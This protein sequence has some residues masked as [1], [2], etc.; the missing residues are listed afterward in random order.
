[1]KNKQV[2]DKHR[3][4]ALLDAFVQGCV[5]RG[6]YEFGTVMEGG[7]VAVR[8]KAS[9]GFGVDHWQRV[10][11]ERLSGAFVMCEVLDRKVIVRLA[12]FEQ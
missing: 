7:R 5:P 8:M 2:P 10:L 9:D 12:D 6:S 11:V 1:M 3:R 4:I